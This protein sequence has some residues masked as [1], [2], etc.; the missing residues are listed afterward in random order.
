VEDL[1]VL[2]QMEREAGLQA[3]PTSTTTAAATPQDS[4]AQDQHIQS[5]SAN[6]APLASPGGPCLQELRNAARCSQTRS[7]MNPASGFRANSMV[8]SE[9]FLPLFVF[10]YLRHTRAKLN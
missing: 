8:R 7:F 4:L 10:M 9:P 3:T 5:A 1:L 6:A 2:D